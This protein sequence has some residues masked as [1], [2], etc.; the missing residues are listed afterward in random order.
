[1]RTLFIFIGLIASCIYIASSKNERICQ[2]NVI[3]ITQCKII[4]YAFFKAIDSIITKSDLKDAPYLEINLHQKL[5]K[6]STVN[7]P[8][9]NVWGKPSSINTSR[10]ILITLDGYNYITPSYNTNIGMITY[11]CHQY[12]FNLNNMVQ[13]HIVKPLKQE[14]I[15]QRIDMPKYEY[16]KTAWEYLHKT[17]YIMSFANNPS[18]TLKYKQILKSDSIYMIDYE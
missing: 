14:Q 18:I 3:Y 16:L 11:K 13:M 8:N 4:D 1:M 7:H 5:Y 12:L 17:K 15:T 2:V 9:L 6:D 10:D